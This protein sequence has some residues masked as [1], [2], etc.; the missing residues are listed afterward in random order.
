MIKR[1]LFG[2][3]VIAILLLAAW[4]YIGANQTGE[5]R[6]VVVDAAGNPIDGATVRLRE[7]TLNLIKE[8]IYTET[9]GMGEFTFTD[10]A[11]IEFFIDARIDGFSSEE[12]RY[13]LYFKEQDFDLPEPIVIPAE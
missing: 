8:G 12:S 1:W 3:A 13:H 4:I 2:L 10:R 7:K 9:N 5:I 11:I 6:G